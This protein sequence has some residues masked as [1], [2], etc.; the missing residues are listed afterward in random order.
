MGIALILV[1]M[2][3]RVNG[4]ILL[5]ILGTTLFGIFRGM[6]HW[7]STW[8]ALPHP[9]LTFLKLDLLGAAHLG[10]AE[11]IF[12]FLFVDLFDN[13]GTLVGVCE[14]GG[15]VQG[16]NSARGE[17]VAGGWHRD[18]GR[19]GDRYIDGDKLHRECCGSGGGG[20]NGFE[21]C[22]GGGVISAGNVFLAAGRGHTGICDCTGVDPVG[23]LMT[24]SIAQVDWGE[25]S[26]AFPLFVTLLATPLTF[27][28][29]TGLS[30]GV[31]SYTVA[32]VAAGKWREVSVLLWILTALF[33]V[34]YAY[35][36]AE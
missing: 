28:I 17:S 11:I 15:F 35:L 6:S 36:A 1:L 7:P 2:V 27:S 5:G 23:A 12:I 21:Q 29:A 20:T 30:L 14:Q 9:S 26:E 19:G 10:L 8:M 31:I 22:D 18:D 33:V 24:Q 16:K 34:R 4:A 3:R 32:K 13:V 25:F